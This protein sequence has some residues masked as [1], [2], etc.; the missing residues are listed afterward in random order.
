M[1]EVAKYDTPSDSWTLVDGNIYDGAK[2]VGFQARLQ[3]MF[4]ADC[5]KDASTAFKTRGK[6]LPDLHP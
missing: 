2:A 4:F 1:I 3:D 5:G 6:E